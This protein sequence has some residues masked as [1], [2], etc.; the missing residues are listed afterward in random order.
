MEC[1][2]EIEFSQEELSK[3][4]KVITTLKSEDWEVIHTKNFYDKD[5]LIAKKYFFR[6]YVY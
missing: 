6:R 5:V 4:D 3:I 2:T 1:F